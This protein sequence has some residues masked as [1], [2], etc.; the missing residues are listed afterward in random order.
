VQITC[1]GAALTVTWT[2]RTA[3]QIGAFSLTFAVT[4]RNV[5]DWR[6]VGIAGRLCE[7][8]GRSFK[9]TARCGAV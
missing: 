4:Q 7:D 5:F 8:V 6:F 1:S 2:V 9:G 3:A